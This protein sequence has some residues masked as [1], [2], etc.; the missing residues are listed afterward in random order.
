MVSRQ[1]IRD[2]LAARLTAAGVN[3]AHFHEP[4]LGGQATA[5]AACGQNAKR[6]LAPLPLAA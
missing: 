3:V 6:L 2:A 1:E 4:D 5:I